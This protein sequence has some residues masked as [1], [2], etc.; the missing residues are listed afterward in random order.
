MRHNRNLLP[1][2]TNPYILQII[3]ID[4]DVSAGWLEEAR[5]ET[6]NGCLARSTGANEGYHLPRLHCHG[7]IAQD[8]GIFVIAE[9]DMIKNDLAFQGW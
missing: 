1:Q 4:E 5:D 8:N 3:A 2:R 7:K 9:T 6:G